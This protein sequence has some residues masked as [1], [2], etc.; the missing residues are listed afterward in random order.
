MKSVR[1]CGCSNG[2]TWVQFGQSNRASKLLDRPVPHQD[3]RY[4]IH[5]L[6]RGEGTAA[7]GVVRVWPVPF[8]D[9]YDVCGLR[10]TKV[11]KESAQHA[12]VPVFSRSA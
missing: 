8:D 10:P 9:G 6:L 2:V 4:E 1:R 11:G 3:P 5:L 7:G 12:G